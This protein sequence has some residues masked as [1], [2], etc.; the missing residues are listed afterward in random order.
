M[1]ACSQATYHSYMQSSRGSSRVVNAAGHSA[2][3]MAADAIGFAIGP[4]NSLVCYD[5]STEL[6]LWSVPFSSP[7]MAAFPAGSD[8]NMLPGMLL[9]FTL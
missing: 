8:A 5:R 6:Q 7:L 1:I 2:S 9:R 3:I 4:G